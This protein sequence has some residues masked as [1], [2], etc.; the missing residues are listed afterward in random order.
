[1]LYLAGIGLGLGVMIREVDG[2]SYAAFV[3]PGLL[4]ASCMNGAISDGFFNVFFKLHFKK[5]Y[6]GVLA[7]P[8]RVPDVACGEMLWALGRA[9]IYAAMFLLTMV[10]AGAVSA[11][12][13]LL[14]P[15]AWLALPAAILVSAAFASLALA[16]T[17][18]ARKVEDFDIVMGLLVMP[19][20]LFSGTFFPVSRMPEAA[21]WLV[22]V[23]PL[24]HAVS[25]LRQ[26]TTGHVAADILVHITYLIV[27]GVAAF[28][29]AMWRLERALIK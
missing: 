25:L 10:V 17:S 18:I 15:T 8:M 3:A 1:V 20:F 28:V 5:T 27:C 19:L 16:L 14:A 4:A 9:S 2:V 24:Y 26:L 12:P 6:D 21:R 29:V 7:T 22:E 23:L 13:M 11:T